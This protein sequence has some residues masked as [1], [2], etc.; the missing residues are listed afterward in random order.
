MTHP[1]FFSP[2]ADRAQVLANH[3]RDTAAYGLR[4]R[5]V[6]HEVRGVE[7]GG[8]YRDGTP[9]RAWFVD[10]HYDDGTT[11]TYGASSQRV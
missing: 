2:D 11:V 8:H 4:Q 9:A 7:L 1:S 5:Y 10:F 6:S 3:E